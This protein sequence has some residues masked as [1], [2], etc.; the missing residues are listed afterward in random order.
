M[1]KRLVG[2]KSWFF[3]IVVLVG[4]ILFLIF[5]LGLVAFLLPLLLALVILGFV[6]SLIFSVFKLKKRKQGKNYVDVK[7]KVKK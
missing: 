7:Y 6:A 1:I 5:L 4:A 3:L 2:V